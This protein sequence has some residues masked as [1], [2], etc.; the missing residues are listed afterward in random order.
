MTYLPT[1]IFIRFFGIDESIKIIKLSKQYNE[2]YY[3]YDAGLGSII[4][5]DV[6]EL[7]QF[8]ES[9][10]I[11]GKEGSIAGAKDTLKYQ[12]RM[13]SSNKRLEQAVEDYESCFLKEFK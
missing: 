5:V 6:G 3:L 8:V 11:I 7:K 2:P 1:N 13:M 4:M 10:D 12:R 9:F